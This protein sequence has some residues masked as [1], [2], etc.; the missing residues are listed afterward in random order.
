[1]KKTVK[2][3]ILASLSFLIILYFLFVSSI[4]K[5]DW[6]YAHKPMYTYQ[7]PFDWF[8]YKVKVN[9]LKSVNNFGKT[10]PQGLPIKKI[11]IDK[12]KQKKLLVDTPLSTK[13][14]QDGFHLNHKNE[15]EDIK[16]RYRGDNPRNWLFEKKHWRI[17]V[18]KNDVKKKQR[19]FDYLPFNLNKYLSGKIANDLGILSP[20]FSLV[21]LY[22]N[23][24]SQ[25][26]YIESENINES[27]LRRNKI[28]PVNI[29]KAEQI[30]NE[31]IVALDG[32]AFNS[33]GILSKTAI[34]NQLDVKDKSDFIFFLELIRLSEKNLDYFKKL[35]NGIGI[36]NFTKFSSYQ[37]LTQNFHNDNSHNFRLILDPWSG[38]ANPIA[39]DPLIGD[40]KD[41][42]FNLDY[43][44]TDLLLL[45]NQSS[46]FQQK[47]LSEI[48]KILKLK[49]IEQ[50]IN[51]QKDLEKLIQVSEKRDI[52]FLLKNFS[53][54]SNKE[55]LSKKSQIER[56]KFFNNYIIYLENL[57]SFLESK[58]NGSWKK[59]K[60]GF[61]IVVENELPIA[62]LKL[63]FDYGAP[64]WIS[65]DT[66][67]NGNLDDNEIKIVKK[68]GDDYFLLPFSFYA[69][70]M[71]YTNS[72]T[73]L[74]HID[75]KI[76]KTRF[77]I[78]SS[79]LSSPSNIEFENFLT[80]EKYNLEKSNSK[81]IFASILNTPIKNEIK[82]EKF[83]ELKGTYNIDKTKIFNNKVKIAAGTVFNLDKN[84]SLIFKNRIIAEGT[85][86]LPI[87]F[88][89]KK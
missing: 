66:N 15:L 60:N 28:M 14:W 48:Y 10:S 73:Y 88:Q 68:P 84:A 42:N 89:K 47:K 74:S 18:R 8:N 75:L 82:S 31:S 85:K 12:K 53:I 46:I 24:I 63:Y 67:E 37:I 30:L 70:R 1:M 57:L 23:D 27:F 76:L 38:E 78:I 22:V 9:Y 49:L 72:T 33:P 17:K 61:E 21:E 36:D 81:G 54:F 56:N 40:L 32:N 35:I 87:I 64:N 79:N 39:Q 34:F 4:I 80:K 19:Y 26:I 50:T 45:L 86:E 52:E 51:Q 13:I 3:L 62:N 2:Y 5:L 43:S 25:G 41:T 29:Y 69:N 77:K 7:N 71:N 11:Y 20:K 44:S 59:N 83:T 55:V 6:N 16:I 58:P 65:L